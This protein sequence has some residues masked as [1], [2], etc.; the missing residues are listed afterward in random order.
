MG[1]LVKHPWGAHPVKHPLARGRKALNSLQPLLLTSSSAVIH[2][3]PS[4][5]L[6]VV[7][8]GRGG[9]VVH[10]LGLCLA[11]L[12][13]VVT[14]ACKCFDSVGRSKSPQVEKRV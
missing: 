11:L 3:A 4:A 12:R 7:F 2:S 6:I 5:L 8:L 13:A 9:D 1:C 14:S 10:V